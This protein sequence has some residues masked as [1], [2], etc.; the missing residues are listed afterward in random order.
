MKF[1]RRQILVVLLMEMCALNV[2]VLHGDPSSSS[3]SSGDLDVDC[4]DKCFPDNDCVGGEKD[5]L[6]CVMAELDA[7]TEDCGGG[8]PGSHPLAMVPAP[9]PTPSSRKK[10]QYYIR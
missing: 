2:L 7:C 4:M 8:S 10:N 9:S 5:Y 1:F 3:S 6:E